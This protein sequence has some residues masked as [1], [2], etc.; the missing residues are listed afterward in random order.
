MDANLVICP[1]IQVLH[2]VF[3]KALRLE[4]AGGTGG[5]FCL[6][7][8][9]TGKPILLYPIGVIPPDKLPRY[10]TFAEEK[11]VRLASNAEHFLSSQS[12][13]PDAEKFSGA[14]RGT[15][16]IFSFSGLR[17]GRGVLDEAMMLVVAEKGGDL[18]GGAARMAAMAVQNPFFDTLRDMYDGIPDMIAADRS[19]RAEQ[20]RR[21]HTTAV[22]CGND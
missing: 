17:E 11:S 6:G 9:A 21:E 19:H 3:P 22:V 8:A 10:L 13:D 15:R 16:F 1:I 7:D 20:V 2:A 4:K 5:I 14:V 18:S 12:A